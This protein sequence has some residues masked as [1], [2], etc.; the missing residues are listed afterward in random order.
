MGTNY[1][2]HLGKDGDDEVN[3]I[4]DP[5]HIG[6]SSVGWCFSLHIYPDKGVSDL[7][8]WEKL[9]CSDNASIRDEYGNVV[10]A[11]V[12]TDIITDRCFNGNKTPGNLMHGQAG[13]NGLWRH[14]IDG[15]LCV[16]HG[17]GT[18]DLFAGDFS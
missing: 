15:D 2:M 11:E 12:M 10:T 3:K 6:K 4:F 13:P 14:R 8:D 7:N 5:V 1:Y 16:G 18:W 9:F 17:R